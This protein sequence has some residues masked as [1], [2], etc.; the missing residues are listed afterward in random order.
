[1]P[2]GGG[3]VAGCGFL[4]L[5]RHSQRRH[6]GL[7]TSSLSNACSHRLRTSHYTVSQKIT[8]NVNKLKFILIILAYYSLKV[9]GF[10]CVHHFPPHL[11]CN[12][13]TLQFIT[14]TD[15]TLSHVTAISIRMPFNKYGILILKSYL[16]KGYTACCECREWCD[17]VVGEGREFTRVQFKDSSHQLVCV[18]R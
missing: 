16:L 12:Y 8:H 9:I 1:M 10:N 5:S 14:I 6:R 3:Y 13:F 2:D 11:V 15:M 4:L 18:F 17:A 7:Q